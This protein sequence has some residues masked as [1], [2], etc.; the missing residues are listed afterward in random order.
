MLESD[1]YRTPGHLHRSHCRS[2]QLLF[3]EF[4][5]EW[6][7]KYPAMIAVWRNSWEQFTPFLKFPAP[8]RK[9]VFR[10]ATRRRGHFPNEQAALKVLYFVIRNPLKNRPNITGKIS[11]W[12][13][14]LDTLALFYGERITEGWQDVS[15]FRP[16]KF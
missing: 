6:E 13:D 2:R 14:I 1:H 5:A 15:P 16:Q 9:L 3:D 11:G 10:Q 4:V 12:K 7:P 8:I